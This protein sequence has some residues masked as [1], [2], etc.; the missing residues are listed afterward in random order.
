VANQNW[1][2]VANQNWVLVQRHGIPKKYPAQKLGHGIPLK[3]PAQVIHVGHECDLA[4]ISVED[5]DFWAGTS[6]LGA[7]H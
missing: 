7:L 4:L 5:D 1:V 3:Y 6:G 2:L